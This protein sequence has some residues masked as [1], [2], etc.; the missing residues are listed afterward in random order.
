MSNWLSDDLCNLATGGGLTKRKLYTDGEE[1]I[2]R[3]CRPIILNGIE[4]IVTRQDLLD[5]SIVVTMVRIS[6][7]KRRPEEQ[8]LK[9]FNRMHPK[10]L[11]ALLD[12]AVLGLQKKE[13]IELERL[14]RM[15]DFAKWVAAALGGEGPKFLAAYMANKDYAVK[16]S[17]EGDP[18]VVSLMN[19]LEIKKG[20][21][22]GTATDLLGFLNVMNG[23][24]SRKSPAGWPRAPNAL[25]S[26]LRRLAPGLRKLG[27]DV[28]FG[29]DETIASR[30][31]SIRKADAAG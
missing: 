30:V 22:S 5:R 10:L 2:L 11:G 12:A 28:E 20:E 16:D 18:V 26:I 9:E 6:D 23:Y 4:D 19:F 24:S 15:A 14:P 8:L 25:S 31:I 21:W 7:E 3:V 29:R 13:S 17:L 27:I 1:T